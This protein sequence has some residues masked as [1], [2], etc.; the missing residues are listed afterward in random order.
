MSE[1]SCRHHGGDASNSHGCKFS[2]SIGGGNHSDIFPLPVPSWSSRRVRSSTILS[3]D[4]G[5]SGEFGKRRVGR[6]AE[7]VRALNTLGCTSAVDIRRGSFHL[8]GHLPSDKPTVLQ[9]AVLR[10][11]SSRVVASGT[12][13]KGMTPKSCFRR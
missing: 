7:S 2:N 8:D 3:D 9:S 11:L 1:P 12:C 5:A 13:P 4:V 10:R 6:I